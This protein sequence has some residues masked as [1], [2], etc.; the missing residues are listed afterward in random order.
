MKKVI[1][2]VV[3]LC[4]TVLG[5]QSQSIWDKEAN[6]SATNVIADKFQIPNAKIFK[7]NLDALK[8]ALNDS[9]LI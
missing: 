3:L 7:L 5:A 6:L 8:E 9:K 1:F 4:A 2:F